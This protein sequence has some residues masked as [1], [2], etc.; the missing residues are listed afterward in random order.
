MFERFKQ[1]WF[2]P[3]AR[4][5]ARLA[6]AQVSDWALR[7][8]LAFSGRGD[9]QGFSLTGIIAGKAWK[10]ECGHP[11]RDFIRGE[12]LRARAELGLDGDMSVLVLNR[13][14]KETLEKRAYRL[15]TDTL[16]TSA[17]PQLPEE[18]RWL[19]I[20]QEVGWGSMPAV[21][22]GR[23]C[24]LAERRT[25]AMA[26]LEPELSSLLLHWPEPGLQATTPFILMLLR[27]KAYLRM[28]YAPADL[29]TLQHATAIFTRACQSALDGLVAGTRGLSSRA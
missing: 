20:Y 26:W 17:D 1:G 4:P 22:W 11:L 9:G 3:T 10:I 6:S 18:M 12:E 16:Q 5:G 24:V 7:Q 2:S 8:G 13:P 14:L 19:A 15:Y 29:P 27:G 25:D 28:E 23:Y 21:F